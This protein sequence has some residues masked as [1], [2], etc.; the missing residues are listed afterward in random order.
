ME[1]AQ[2]T[3]N[4]L[5]PPYGL[6]VRKAVMGVCAAISIPRLLDPDG[7]TYIIPRVTVGISL[8]IVG[9]LL[10]LT[11]TRRLSILGRIV[12]ALAFTTFVTLAFDSLGVSSTSALIVAVMAV[13][14]F[15]EATAN[16]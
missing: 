14:M 3:K 4:L 2:K 10:A 6:Q 9:I 8:A 15:G 7:A 1:I 5:R 11:M 12:S 16:D 13:C